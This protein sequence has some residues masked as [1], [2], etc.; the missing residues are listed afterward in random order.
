[1]LG[2]NERK[3]RKDI[4]YNFENVCN[5]LPYRLFRYKKLFINSVRH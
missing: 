5:T 2:T 1:M 3:E 4:I